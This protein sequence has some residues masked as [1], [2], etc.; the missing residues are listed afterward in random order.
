MD[1]KLEKTEPSTTSVSDVASGTVRDIA[2]E[3]DP[4]LERRTLRKFDKYLLPPLA[5]I[6]LLAYLDRSNLG[7]AKVFGF[8]EGLGLEG[9]QFNIISTCFYPA[10]VVLETPWTMAV[11]R[12][13]AKHVLGVAMVSWSIITM[14]TGFIHN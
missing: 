8:E 9:N 4:A 11:K 7:N 13:G 6:L 10:Y 3:L 5:V 1:Q 12:Y 14:C 2:T